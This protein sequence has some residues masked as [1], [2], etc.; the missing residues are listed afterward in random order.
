MRG[1][2]R[3]ACRALFA[4]TAAVAVAVVLLALTGCSPI[5]PAPVPVPPPGDGGFVPAPEGAVTVQLDGAPLTVLVGGPDGMR[6]RTDFG[7]ADG[8]LFDHGGAIDP[9]SVAWVMDGVPIPLDIAWFDAEGRFVGRTTMQPC[10]A[11]PC[12]QHRPDV[13][14]RWALEAPTGA[15]DGL[16]AASRLDVA[17]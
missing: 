11:E 3:A 5:G 1:G 17:F 12:P 4:V 13:P 10:A 7:G 14:Y 16:S 15:F 9:G 2:G 8:M 6:G